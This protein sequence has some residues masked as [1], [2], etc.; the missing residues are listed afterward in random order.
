MCAWKA[1]TWDLC[2][3][4]QQ[5]AEKAI[6]GMLM[7]RGVEFRY[8]HDL[9]RLVTLLEESRLEIPEEV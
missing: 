5:A 9:G 8:V 7:H 4:A 2:F 3:E 6:K 1:F